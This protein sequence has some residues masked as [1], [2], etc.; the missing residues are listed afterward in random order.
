MKKL[1]KSLKSSSVV[2]SEHVIEAEEA[3]RATWK[4]MENLSELDWVF[5]VI[6]EEIS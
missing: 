1:N 4:Q 3:S 2:E 6:N 5:S